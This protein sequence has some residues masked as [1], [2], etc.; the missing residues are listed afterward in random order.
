MSDDKNAEKPASASP[1]L[2]VSLGVVFLCV[3]VVFFLTMS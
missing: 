1:A 3:G 2:W